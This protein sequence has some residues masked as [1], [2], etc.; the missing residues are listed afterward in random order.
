MLLR[1]L[2]LYPVPVCW[3][4]FCVSCS[5]CACDRLRQFYRER[6]SNW[7]FTTSGLKEVYSQV[8]LWRNTC[9]S[10]VILLVCTQLS[11]SLFALICKWMGTATENWP[12]FIMNLNKMIVKLCLI[13]FTSWKTS[14]WSV[15]RIARWY[16]TSCSLVPRRSATTSSLNVWLHGWRLPAL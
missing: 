11:F 13:N 10:T 3:V 12:M 15:V 2:A 9:Y 1:R 5:G 8:S 14:K 7:N 6:V 4:I 16:R